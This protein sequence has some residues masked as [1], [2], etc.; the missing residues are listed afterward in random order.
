VDPTGSFVGAAGCWRLD[1]ACTLSVT[2]ARAV[3]AGCPLA[4]LNEP[5]SCKK[6]VPPKS[7]L[8]KEKKSLIKSV[9]HHAHCRK[10]LHSVKAFNAADLPVLVGKSAREEKVNTGEVSLF[11]SFSRSVFRDGLR[12]KPFVTKTVTALSVASNAG[13]VISSSVSTYSGFAG[14]TDYS[15]LIQIFDEVKIHSITASVHP[16]NKYSKATT[17]SGPIVFVYDHDDT[18]LLTSYNQNNSTMQISNTDDMFS[19][20]K[21]LHVH[22][23]YMGIPGEGWVSIANINSG[24]VGLQGAFKYY[25]NALS[26]S[27]SYGTA[28][29]T[30]YAEWRFQ[31]S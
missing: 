21:E 22:F 27:Y 15:L 14:S 25:A 31:G 13:G 16:W 4:R 5:W 28:F 1:C 23:P 2:V 7:N 30:F 20:R 17:L 6:S 3:G 11:R 18:S 29:Y 26:N 8:K 9:S 12:N 10:L 19:G 24:T